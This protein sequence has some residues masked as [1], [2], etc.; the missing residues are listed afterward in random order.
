MCEHTFVA[1]AWYVTSKGGLLAS[2][3]AQCFGIGDII[4]QVESV[5]RDLSPE[6]I[7]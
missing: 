7:V 5:L 4:G 1:A 6:H 3:G 2:R